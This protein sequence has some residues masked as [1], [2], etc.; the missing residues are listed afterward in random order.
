M[1]FPKPSIKHVSIMLNF[2]ICQQSIMI[3]LKLRLP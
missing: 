2:S 1:F 3:L